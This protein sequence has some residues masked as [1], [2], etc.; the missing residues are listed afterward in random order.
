MLALHFSIRI[1]CCLP[2]QLQQPKH[3]QLLLVHCC[4]LLATSKNQGMP[5]LQRQVVTATHVTSNTNPDAHTL[6]V[7]MLY[8]PMHHQAALKAQLQQT[9]KR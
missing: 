3:E 2:T 1:P 9:R 6:F 5:L 8:A 4:A 7:C